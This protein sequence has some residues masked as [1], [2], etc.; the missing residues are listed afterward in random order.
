MQIKQH[1]RNGKHPVGHHQPLRAMT[2]LFPPPRPLTLVASSGTL[3][4]ELHWSLNVGVQCVMTKSTLLAPPCLS[5]FSQEHLVSWL[6][7]FLCCLPYLSKR[8]FM[9]RYLKGLLPNSSTILSY[10]L[11]VWVFGKTQP[12]PNLILHL[13]WKNTHTA[14]YLWRNF[15]QTCRLGYALMHDF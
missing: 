8:N 6:L 4:G 3:S 13:F 1:P 10:C 11:A 14:Q 2:F 15:I 7:S 12:W 9:L 5:S